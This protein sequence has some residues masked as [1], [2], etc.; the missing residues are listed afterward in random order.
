MDDTSMD[1]GESQSRSGDNRRYGATDARS[2]GGVDEGGRRGMMRVIKSICVN[3]LV[4]LASLALFAGI[5]ELAIRWYLS[6]H[7]VYD[8]EMSRYANLIKV[9]SPNPKIGFVHKPNSDAVLMNAPVRINSDGLRDV[10]HAVRHGD[11][12]RVIFLGDSLT[13]GWGVRQEESFK[14]ILETYLNTRYPA[15]ILNFG[16][17]NYNSEQEVNLFLEKGLKYHPDKVVVFYFINDAE[18]TPRKSRWEFLAHSRLVTFYWSRIHALLSNL[19]SDG[20]DFRSY[21][22]GLYRDGAPGWVNAQRAFVQL[23]DV[24]A[25]EGIELQVVLLPELHQLENYPFRSQHE[26]V[27]GF[28]KGNGIEVLDLAPLLEDQGDPM[29]LWVAQDD[30]HPNAIASRL[31]A[32]RSVEFIA[33]RRS[34]GVD[35]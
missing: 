25:Q 27:A 26:Q 5:G 12:Y 35:H 10:E 28:L 6:T 22:A 19:G 15:E 20:S 33:K 21:Y 11:A 34:D 8:I 24:C 16:I 17:G 14:S 3:M 7:T 32:D 23:R 30:A 9:D 1:V 13:L 29:R 31:I 4:V 18:P 2:D